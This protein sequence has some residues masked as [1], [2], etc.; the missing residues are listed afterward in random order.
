MKGNLLRTFGRAAGSALAVGLLASV[1]APALAQVT[2]ER[3]ENADAEPN[4]WLTVFQ[5]YS[6]HRFSRLDEITRENVGNLHMAFAVPLSFAMRG[7]NSANL[8][9]APLVIDGMLYM[10]DEWGTVYKVDVTSG[11]QGVVQWIADPAMDKAGSRGILTT[12]GLAAFGNNIYTNLV[13]GRVISTDATTG[14][15]VWDAQIA[16]TE[17]DWDFDAIEGFTAAPLAVEGRILVG[18]SMGDW[19]TRGWLAAVNADTGEEMWRRYAI[20]NP[21][22]A[23]HET[24]LDDHNAYRTGGAAMWTTGS[25]DPATRLT[26]WGTANPVPMY[27]PEF[28]PGDNL[29]TN[30]ALAINIDDGS[31]AWY[32]QYSANES[33]DYDEIGVHLLYD[34]MIDGEN[35]T[36]VGH[37][38]RNG[39]YYQLDRTTGSFINANQYV[40]SVT[41]TAGIDPKTGKPV[42]YDPALAVQTY[43]PATRIA[44]DNPAIEVCPSHL[45]GVRWQPTAYNP[46]THIAYVAGSD[47]CSSI[48][49]APEVP[50][51][52]G[53]NP[54]GVGQV[55]LG[56]T[57]TAHPDPGLIAALDV[58]TGQVVATAHPPQHN[59]AGVLA[60]AGGLI[61]TGGQDGAVVALNDQ[62]LEELWRFNG[63]IPFKA[64]PISYA[65]GDKQFIAIIAG[66]SGGGGYAD[67]N[68][69]GPRTGAMLYVF[70]L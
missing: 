63:G 7:T 27:D 57:G 12:R 64:P 55:W 34:A 25:Y 21:G 36:V 53:G 61:F 66:G 39:Y 52:T 1:S 26:I 16:R 50:V 17:A 69:Q 45:G 54:R 30:S 70:A 60:T 65:I 56:G 49:N 5:N 10:N 14:E 15:I 46:I 35:R 38:G 13:D 6:S 40:S 4:N 18:Q 47:A 43:I 48:T 31:I 44:R 42:E 19:G 3:L 41:W 62:T 11:T 67:L 9:N 33:W 51:A 32:F 8:E 20:P 22:E 24:W 2:Q 23:G 68:A 29:F 37:Y 28:R 59:L 58:T